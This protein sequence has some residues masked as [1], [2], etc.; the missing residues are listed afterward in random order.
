MA[1]RDA[2]LLLADQNLTLG[3]YLDRWL[4]NSVRC[5]VKRRTFERYEEM[6]RLHIKPVL[7]AKKLSKLRSADVQHLCRDRLDSGLSAGTVHHVHV[8]L[9]KAL[10]RAVEWD[11]ALRSV[12]EA[13]EV[14][15]ASKEETLSFSV[16]S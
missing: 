10:R 11:L 12:T 13:A 5:S 4:S 8:T 16:E 9:H 1:D 14:P 3:E 2:R 15:K 7:G 6:V